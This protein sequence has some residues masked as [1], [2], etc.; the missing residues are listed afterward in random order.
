M[1]AFKS[2]GWK[3]LSPCL[4]S[5]LVTGCSGIISGLIAREL[6]MEAE[7]V[8]SLSALLADLTTRESELRG[9]L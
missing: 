7:R 3:G 9:Y 8:N 1:L 2:V 5:G 4:G 6:I